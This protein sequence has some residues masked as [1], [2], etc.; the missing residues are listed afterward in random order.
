MSKRLVIELDTC[1]ECPECT[2]T[3]S[4]PY[5]APN[6]GIAK[7]LELA[8]HE[9]ACRRCEA[10]SCVDACP[11]EALEADEDGVLRRYNMRCT[12]C[13]SCSVACPFGNIL[14]A[15]LQ[16][17][18]NASDF[19]AGRHDGVPDC[20]STCPLAALAYEED[21]AEAPDLHLVGDHLAVRAAVWQRMEPAAER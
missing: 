20:V 16:F 14:P 17:D 8:A 1:R 12:G 2:A 18:D 15:A 19:C 7:L 9:V 11:N 5:H 6:D 10:R 4:Y 21:P 13:L 3:C